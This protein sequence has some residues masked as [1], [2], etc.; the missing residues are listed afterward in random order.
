MQRAAC[1]APSFA[2]QAAAAPCSRERAA[3]LPESPASLRPRFPNTVRRTSPSSFL[4]GPRPIRRSVFS[5][6]ESG[7][8]WG[9]T[10]PFLPEK[11]PVE[12]AFLTTAAKAGSRPEAFF[13]PPPSENTGTTR[14]ALR[15]AVDLRV[16]FICWLRSISINSTAGYG[17][18]GPAAANATPSPRAGPQP[19]SSGSIG[20][21]N[22]TAR[23]LA[24]VF[25][26]P[27]DASCGKKIAL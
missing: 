9:S 13:A 16:T 27:K 19:G 18:R 4:R 2:I 1:A 5:T 11:M 24:I 6:A 15:P 20:N 17:H 3:F 14:T 12:S 25:L 21:H 23:T 10:S 8:T 22:T 7:A 26:L